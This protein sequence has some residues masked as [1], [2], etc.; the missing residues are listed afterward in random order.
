MKYVLIKN[1]DGQIKIIDNSTRIGKGKV[2]RE[3]ADGGEYVGSIE[4]E[5]R[6]MQIEKGFNVYANKRIRNLREQLDK[7]W[8]VF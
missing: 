4:S 1:A 7:I 3:I 6:P 8:N 5:L 2:E